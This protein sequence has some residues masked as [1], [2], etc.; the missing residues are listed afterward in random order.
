MDFVPF[1]GVCST[2]EYSCTSHQPEKHT[3]SSCGEFRTMA[4]R[5]QARRSLAP[6]ERIATATMRG[7]WIVCCVGKRRRHPASEA[8]PRAGRSISLSRRPQESDTSASHP[9]QP[10]FLTASRHPCLT[11]SR[12][13]TPPPPPGR[14]NDSTTRV[15]TIQPPRSFSP[16]R[17]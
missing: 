9:R 10:R 15:V 4:R 13:P 2:L 1:D 5:R 8:Y 14:R 11:P 12:L 6:F 7:A 17:Q 16:P 3:T